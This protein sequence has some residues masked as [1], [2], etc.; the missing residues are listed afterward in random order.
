MKHCIV[1]LLA[2]FCSLFCSAQ[3]NRNIWGFTL[4]TSRSRE[5]KSYATNHNMNWHE[6]GGPGGSGIYEIDEDIQTSILFA[7]QEWTEAEF[8]FVN[9][10]LN[11]VSFTRRFEDKDQLKETFNVL[12]EALLAKYKDYISPFAYDDQEC[13][14][15]VRLND[16][17]VVVALIPFDD[18]LELCLHYMYLN[19]SSLD[20]L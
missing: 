19:D 9:D 13:R 17:H 15:S 12:R 6:I 10:M 11:N 1:I 14:Y 16:T 3:I 18:D 4:G 7:G 20:D 5:F 2:I 8:A